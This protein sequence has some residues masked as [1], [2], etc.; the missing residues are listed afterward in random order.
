MTAEMLQAFDEFQQARAHIIRAAELLEKN[1]NIKF[2]NFFCDRPLTDQIR[3]SLDKGIATMAEEAQGE[4]HDGGGVLSYGYL[5]IG[6]IRFDQDKIPIPV[7]YESR[8]V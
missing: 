7:Q 2:K 3:V 8:Y 6:D 4:I 5:D 1:E